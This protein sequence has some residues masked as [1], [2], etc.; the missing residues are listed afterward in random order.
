[1]LIVA[2]IM[3]RSSRSEIW[4]TV[5]FSLVLTFQVSGRSDHYLNGLT[6]YSSAIVALE[7]RVFFKVAEK[8][9]LNHWLHEQGVKE[10]I[11]KVAEGYKTG[12]N[13]RDLGRVSEQILKQSRKYGYDPLFLTAL[14]ITES[15]FNNWARSR[16]GALGLMQIK[17]KTGFAIANETNLKWRG[18]ET[19][20]DPNINIVLGVY[21]LDK[22]VKRFGNLQ[23]ALEAYNHGPSQLSYFLRRGYRPKRYSGRVFY[24]YQKIKAQSV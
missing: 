4:L 14:I 19:L 24:Y 20:F 22:L 15:S 1:M 2:R 11:L 3:C 21:Y 17:P 7:H 18:R 23:L 16:K 8:R 12:L 6:P 5:I 13:S 10:R 9:H